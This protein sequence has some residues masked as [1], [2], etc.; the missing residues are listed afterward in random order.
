MWDCWTCVFLFLQCIFCFVIIMWFMYL[1]GKW[2]IVISEW[3]AGEQ[4][5][6]ISVFLYHSVTRILSM[7]ASLYHCIIWT[8]CNFQSIAQSL[9]YVLCS[10]CTFHACSF[11]ILYYWLVVWCGYAASA[12]LTAIHFLWRL[13]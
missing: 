5:W 7:S 9:S 13:V 8:F 4:F 10:C 3:V 6:Y 1:E 11:M 2:R 12:N